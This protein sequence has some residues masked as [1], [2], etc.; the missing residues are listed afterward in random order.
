MSELVTQGFHRREKQNIADGGTVG[1]EHH[2]AVD[3]EAEAACRRH[4]VLQCIDEVIIHLCAAIRLN[5]LALG[6]LTLEA[7]ALVDR[8]VQLGEGVADSKRSVNAGSSG[9]RLASGLISTG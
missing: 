2:E 6:D 9:L 5:G 7:A 3:A 8:V 1:Q 4:A